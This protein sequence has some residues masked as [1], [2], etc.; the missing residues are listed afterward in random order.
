MDT[1]TVTI[2]LDAVTLPGNV[3][4]TVTIACTIVAGTATF[5]ITVK[6]LDTNMVC[7]TQQQQPNPTTAT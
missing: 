5:K 1:V 4:V 3:I 7:R 6:I 2:A